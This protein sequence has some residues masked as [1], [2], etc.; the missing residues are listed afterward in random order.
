MSDPPVTEAMRSDFVSGAYDRSN[1]FGPMF[2]QPTEHEERSADAMAIET[3]KDRVRTLSDTTWLEQ[4]VVARHHGLQRLHLE[5]LFDIDR[6]E[7][8]RW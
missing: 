4:P 8:C 7:M 2:G 5:V 1:Y 3:L 6:K